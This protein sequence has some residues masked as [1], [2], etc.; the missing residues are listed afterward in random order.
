[1]DR[2]ALVVDDSALIRNEIGRF[3]KK[4]GYRVSTAD[5]GLEGLVRLEEL[6]PSLVV[7]G[8][9]M[10]KLNGSEFIRE[11]R[12]RC[13]NQNV[14]IIAVAGIRGRNVPSPK[15]G[16]DHVIFKGVDLVEQLQLALATSD[17]MKRSAKSAVLRIRAANE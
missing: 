15:A 13:R 12:H 7:T 5:N 1:M 10:P 11:I 4:L 17:T 14:A 6:V 2:V 8:L 9:M 16:A 3:L